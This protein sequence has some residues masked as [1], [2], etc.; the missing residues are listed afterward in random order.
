MSTSI[1]M[2]TFLY[3]FSLTNIY[4]S[5]LGSDFKSLNDLCVSFAS[6]PSFF[7]TYEHLYIFIF[8]VFFSLQMSVFV[9]ML[10]A[11]LCNPRR[12][13]ILSFG[14]NE[15][16]LCHLCMY[17]CSMDETSSKCLLNKVKII[18]N[19][20][21]LYEASMAKMHRRLAFPSKKSCF[22]FNWNL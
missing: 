2:H 1:H 5:I 22:L 6:S 14:L 13:A 18:A 15:N 7:C 10:C 12:M 16:I 4:S 17:V 21:N 20:N 8:E 9:S 3:P 11:C 19:A